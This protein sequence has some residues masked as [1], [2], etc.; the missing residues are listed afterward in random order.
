M[1]PSPK[2]SDYERALCAAGSLE[3]QRSQHLCFRAPTSGAEK[4]LTGATESRV[5]LESSTWGGEEENQAEAYYGQDRPGET[6]E[7]NLNAPF[8][9]ASSRSSPRKRHPS[10]EM[11]AMLRPR[12]AEGLEIQRENLPK[13]LIEGV[14]R[15]SS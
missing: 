7:D 13:K 9:Y 10:A 3:S 14:E 1:N 5:H 4:T 6:R 8:R 11:C 2:R 12:N 15:H